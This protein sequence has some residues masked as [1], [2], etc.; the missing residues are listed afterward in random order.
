[1]RQP[2]NSPCVS[3]LPAN[4]CCPLLLRSSYQR[5]NLHATL[6]SSSLAITIAALCPLLRD[7]MYYPLSS[8]H[9]S[10]L[11]LRR[12]L[13]C[14]ALIAFMSLQASVWTVLTA[15]SIL[16]R[17]VSAPGACC[18]DVACKYIRTHSA[19][20]DFQWSTAHSSPYLAA[21]YPH[22]RAEWAPQRVW[23]HASGDVFSLF[24]LHRAACAVPLASIC[25]EL[26]PVQSVKQAC[27]SRLCLSQTQPGH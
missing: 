10:P 9:A 13:A 17:R 5:L 22:M 8:A 1:M 23:Y 24:T 26:V 21:H 7:C 6:Q 27:H 11:S 16:R 12:L 19:S 2:A 20:S 4:S 14:Q 25:A 3:C 18:N 15:R